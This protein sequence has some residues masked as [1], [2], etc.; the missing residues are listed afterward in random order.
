MSKYLEGHQSINN[1]SPQ[2]VQPVSEIQNTDADT[3]NQFEQTH[4]KYFDLVSDSKMKLNFGIAIIPENG[5]NKSVITS[6]HILLLRT[7][8]NE[9]LCWCLIDSLINIF[10]N[11]YNVNNYVH[12]VG[13]ETGN[14]ICNPLKTVYKS[15]KS[16]K[17]ICINFKLNIVNFIPFEIDGFYF[18]GIF[19]TRKKTFKIEAFRYTYL[20]LEIRYQS[21]IM[22][23]FKRFLQDYN[24]ARGTSME[25][26]LVLPSKN[27]VKSTKIKPDRKTSG[28][29]FLKKCEYLFQI[30]HSKELKYKT[31]SLNFTTFYP[32]A[33]RKYLLK[34]LFNYQMDYTILCIVCLKNLDC[35]NITCKKCKLTIHEKCNKD[36]NSSMKSV[37]EDK[38]NLCFLCSD[39]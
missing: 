23:Y 15:V 26:K 20:N 18:L 27:L 22:D 29:F 5:V 24:K 13:L 30:I 35:P 6:E 2:P 12:Y 16:S 34:L 3:V 14:K 37:A 7:I 21:K 10:I 9:I 31:A 1:T 25:A 8:G 11:L 28:H 38:T 4:G 19:D 33:Y 17:Q 32:S 36:M 39:E